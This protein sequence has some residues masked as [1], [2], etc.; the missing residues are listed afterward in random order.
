MLLFYNNIQGNRVR[1]RSRA[2]D[3]SQTFM[4]GLLWGTMSKSV[5]IEKPH[6][7]EGSLWD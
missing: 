3:Y 4:W 1:E 5:G 7:F 6:T 2:C